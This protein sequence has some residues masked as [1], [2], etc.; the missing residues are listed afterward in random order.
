MA[1]CP[2]SVRYISIA[3]LKLNPRN[4]RI[5]TDKQVA[6]L[7]SSIGAF[8][9]NVPILI[10]AKSNVIAGHGR[11]C[12]AKVLGIATVPTIRLEHLSEQQIRAF[13]IA[14]NRLTENAAWDQQL[15]GEQL[16]ILS[17]A[18]IDFSLETTGFEMGEIDLM[19]ENLSLAPQGKEDPADAMPEASSAVVSELG[20]LWIL[21]KHKVLCGNALSLADYEMLMDGHK[22]NVVFTDPPYNVRIA[23]HASGNGKTSHRE[24]VMASGEMSELEFRQFLTQALARVAAS[25]RIPSVIYVCIDWRHMG[26]L[27]AAGCADHLDLLNVCVWTKDNAGMGSL[28]RSQHELV[29]AFRNGKASHRNNIQLGRFGRSRSNVWRYPGANTFSRN[30]SEGNL[31]ALHPTVK[32]VALVADAIMDCSSRGERVLDPFLG[33][34]TTVIAAERTGRICHGMELDPIY[35]DTAVR[36]WQ[37]F[38]GGTAVHAANGRSFAEMEEESNEEANQIKETKVRKRGL[39]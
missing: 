17:E 23:G 16:K 6:Q 28:Y 11:V 5:H 25:S 26:E 30:T 1:Q 32:P 34:G 18:E 24:F 12:A 31:L 13:G 3:R 9:F 22:A 2:L 10:D 14:D 7:A 33:S 15:L 21:G 4:T 37:E 27:L 19:I 29:F 35:V 38:T 39:R 8:G 36:R 20:D